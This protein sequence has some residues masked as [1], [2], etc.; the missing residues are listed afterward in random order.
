MKRV[1]LVDTAGWNG[2][3]F[4]RKFDSEEEALRKYESIPEGSYR[5]I[6]SYIPKAP[7]APKKY[8]RVM[9]LWSDDD[10]LLSVEIKSTL[11]FGGKPVD[12][13]SSPRP[14][15]MLYESYFENYREAKKFKNRVRT[16]W[17][18]DRAAVQR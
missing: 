11:S 6:R 15:Q 14:E 18:T 4:T 16:A 12:C 8:W 10:E 7:E 9:E 17:E 5:H 13:G 1:W 3:I 2:E